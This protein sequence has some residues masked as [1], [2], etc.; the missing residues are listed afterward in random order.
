MLLLAESY[1]FNPAYLLIPLAMCS[2]CSWILPLDPI[3]LLT[4]G[5]GYYTVGDMIKAGLVL[6]AVTAVITGGWIS[7]ISMIS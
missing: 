4:F 1:G 5:R 6:T 2:N 7:V 3:A